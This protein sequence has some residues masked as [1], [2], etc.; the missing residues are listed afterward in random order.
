M[1]GAEHG[2]PKVHNLRRKVAAG[3]RDRGGIVAG[4]GLGDLGRPLSRLPALTPRC[5]RQRRSLFPS[6]ERTFHSHACAQGH[7]RGRFSRM[8]SG[9]RARGRPRREFADARLD[10]HQG[11]G[12]GVL[13][14]ASRAS[15]TGRIK[16]T[17]HDNYYFPLLIPLSFFAKEAEH[18]EGFAKEMAVVTHHR[19]KIDRRRTEARSRSRADRAADHPPDVGDD[20]RRR[21]Q[22]LDQVVPR[23]AAEAEPVGQRDALGDAHASLPA[24]LRVPL[25]GGPHRPRR[26]SATRWKKP[27]WRSNSIA[28]SPK[29]SSPSP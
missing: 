4:C 12:H 11:L 29:T 3:D 8:V 19:L 7:A 20:H 6:P 10:D 25:A 21:V 14:T 1:P 9:G 26:R 27:C 22:P 2:A 23:P 16:E 5:R 13:G 15:S 24:H 28:R 18:V 17:G